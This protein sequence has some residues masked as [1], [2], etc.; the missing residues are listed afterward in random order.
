M[1]RLQQTALS[2]MFWAGCNIIKFHFNEG[3]IWF[4][5][6]SWL[7][8]KQRTFCV[9]LVDPRQNHFAFMP[10][11]PATVYVSLCICPMRYNHTIHCYHLLPVFLHFTA[12][13]R[14][15]QGG[16]EDG[17]Q[18]KAQR[19]CGRGTLGAERCTDFAACGRVGQPDWRDGRQQLV[20]QNV[21]LPYHN[22]DKSE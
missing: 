12:G 8:P 17:Q 3:P 6:F 14:C 15:T 16:E 19:T 11:R 13:A 9:L 22:S 21:E 10:K 4:S 7:F 5:R 20:V 1:Q 18:Q 2:P